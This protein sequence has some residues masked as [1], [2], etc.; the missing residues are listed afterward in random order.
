MAVLV[1]VDFLTGRYHGRNAQGN[2]DWPP[3]PSRVFQALVAG[4]G[5]RTPEQTAALLAVE[6]GSAPV[7]IASP[8][9]VWGHDRLIYGKSHVAAGTQGKKKFSPSGSETDLKKLMGGYIPGFSHRGIG[10][11]TESVTVAGS[12]ELADTRVSYIYEGADKFV[13]ILDEIATNIG[14]VG[15]A[16]DMV[17][18]S[19][20]KCESVMG[21]T[22]QQWEQQVAGRQMLEPAHNSQVKGKQL[23]VPAP[24]LLQRLDARYESKAVPNF[25][26]RS[27]HPTSHM[28]EQS[29]LR[30]QRDAGVF[31]LR[32]SPALQGPGA[33][34]VLEQLTEKGTYP[35]FNPHRGDKSS[36]LTGVVSIGSVDSITQRYQQLASLLIELTDTEPEYGPAGWEQVLT[37]TSAT[38]VSQSPLVMPGGPELVK[39]MVEHELS[40]QSGLSVDDLEVVVVPARGQGRV[41]VPICDGRG[42]RRWH[43]DVTFSD[44]VTG[45]FKV[46][47]FAGVLVPQESQDE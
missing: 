41:D 40:A 46:G 28:P 2:P 14:Y 38:W 31:S 35:W 13:D 18:V 43:V 37:S 3:A 22:D 26:G 27:G 32:I 42:G 39:A 44:V 4:A 8:D 21:W 29:Y 25:K 6:N 23:R 1:E 20:R 17:S 30:M 34:R 10:S 24:G 11:S 19:V 36:L 9:P 16:V 15:T 12:A 45:P 47:P 7:I 5:H 33:A